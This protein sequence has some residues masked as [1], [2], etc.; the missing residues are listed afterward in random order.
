MLDGS[1]H[2]H[3]GGIDALGRHY[4]MYLIRILLKNGRWRGQILL[5][6]SRLPLR[7]YSEELILIKAR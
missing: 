5:S 6:L 3:L 2:G 4:W 1:R 7:L